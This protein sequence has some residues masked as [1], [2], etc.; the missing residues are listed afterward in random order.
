MGQ[1]FPLAGLTMGL[2]GHMFDGSNGNGAG[3]TWKG[4]DMLYVIVADGTFDQV[5]ETKAQ[6]NKERRDLEKMGCEVKVRQCRTWDEVHA[7]E[8]KLNG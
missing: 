3:R 6:A 7:L 5:C 2:G 1:V 8:D 4:T